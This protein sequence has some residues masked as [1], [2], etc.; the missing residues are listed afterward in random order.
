MYKEARSR[1]TFSMRSPLRRPRRSLLLL[2]LLLLPSKHLAK[3]IVRAH[4][5]ELTKCEAKQQAEREL[6]K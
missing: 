6:K 2:M 1:T 4:K 3:E 5:V